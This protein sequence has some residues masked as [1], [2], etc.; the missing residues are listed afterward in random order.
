MKKPFLRVTKWLG[1]IPV[2]AG[3]TSCAG[4][5]FQVR[6]PSHRPMRKEYQEALQRDFDHHFKTVH[7]RESASD[8]A[9]GSSDDL[10]TKPN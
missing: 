1:D 4:L 5:K 7:L 6:S 2:E 9:A 10:P 8:G 3:C